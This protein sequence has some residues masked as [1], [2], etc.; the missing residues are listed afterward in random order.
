MNQARR[1]AQ[2][3]ANEMT[4]ALLFFRNWKAGGFICAVRGQECMISQ[5]AMAELRYGAIVKMPSGAMLRVARDGT[6][7]PL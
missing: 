5:G 1:E 2:R 3:M 4:E 7:K 6:F